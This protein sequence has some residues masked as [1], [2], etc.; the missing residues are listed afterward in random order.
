MTNDSQLKASS[1]FS[2]SIATVISYVLHPVYFPVAMTWLVCFLMP[3]SFDSVKNFHL[4]FLLARVAYLTIFFPVLTVLLLKGLG[5]IVSIQLKN[6]RERIIPIIASMIFY[7]WAYWVMKNDTALHAPK[8][9]LTVFLGVFWG[10][11]CLFMANIFV[12]VSM[13]ATAAGAL[14]GLIILFAFQ[15]IGN[16]II[17][18]IV[19][20]VIAAIIGWARMILSAHKI[21]EVWFGYVIGV[22]SMIAAYGY[23]GIN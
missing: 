22:V 9:I 18:A 13:H 1:N 20:I 3:N 7:F 12:K 8:M 17:P 2:K 11:I 4:G 15:N 10:I 5:F 19:S 14:L 6:H 16:I 23:L 21:S